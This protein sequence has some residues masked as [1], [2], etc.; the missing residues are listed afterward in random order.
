MIHRKSLL[1]LFAF[2]LFPILQCTPLPIHLQP[3]AEPRLPVHPQP[4][5]TRTQS[6]HAPIATI[7]THS[8]PPLPSPTYII[9]GSSASRENSDQDVPSLYTVI[10]LIILIMTGICLSVMALVACGYKLYTL[11]SR[12]ISRRRARKEDLLTAIS[13]GES[14]GEIGPSRAVLDLERGDMESV[15]EIGLEMST[16][17]SRSVTTNAE[18]PGSSSTGWVVATEKHGTVRR[19]KVL[20]RDSVLPV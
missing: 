14:A 10:V 19:V 6:P 1:H 5:S 13:V 8:N 16:P 18:N 2:L 20:D 15:R 12:Y 7:T 11:L 17:Y 3:N 4:L 9:H